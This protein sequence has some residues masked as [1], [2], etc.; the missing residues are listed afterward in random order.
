MTASDELVGSLALPGPPPF[1][2]GALSRWLRRRW[3][4]RKYWTFY[5][6]AF[7]ND[8]TKTLAAL[9]LMETQQQIV[10]AAWL[11]HEP[12]QRADF[13]MAYESLLLGV[14][15]REHSTIASSATADSEI[16]A[17]LCKLTPCPEVRLAEMRRLIERHFDSLFAPGQQTGIPSPWTRAVQSCREAGIS[18]P[19]ITDLSF[20]MHVLQTCIRLK[21][22]ARDL[23]TSK[24]AA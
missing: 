9:L 24:A 14:V 7:G 2:F 19:F 11:A 18:L 1:P 15:V 20:Q 13:L 10:K 23:P 6:A 22:A 12:S 17:S 16:V 5:N 4:L 8:L 21:T 3:A